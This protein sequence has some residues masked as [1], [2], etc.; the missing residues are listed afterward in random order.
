M[1]IIA[2]IQPNKYISDETIVNMFDNNPDGGGLMW[3]LHPNSRVKI[4][5]GFE[6]VNEL[7]KVFRSIPESAERAIHCRIATAGKIS[8]GCCHPFPLRNSTKTMKQAKDES[9][10][11]YMHNGIIDWCNPIG[12]H[13]DAEESDTMIFGRDILYR[14]KNDLDN[15]R[16]LDMIE[17][18]I[19]SSKLLI[20]R[21]NGE[22]IVLGRWVKDKNGILYS[23]DTYKYSYYNY[24]SI[25]WRGLS[26]NK[27]NSLFVDDTAQYDWLD[28]PYASAYC[29]GYCDQCLSTVCEYSNNYISNTTVRNTLLVF[30]VKKETCHQSQN[31]ILNDIES[32][33]YKVKRSTIHEADKVVEIDVVVEGGA[34]YDSKI[35][36]WG[37]FEP[38][39]KELL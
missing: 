5:K 1:C 21:N 38:A 10:I 24:S 25:N 27:C 39:E 7:I 30:I 32:K 13:M 28:N 33:G 8:V 16:I 26:D 18:S 2:Y 20:F 14:L 36:K 22:T 6:D 12:K 37:G 23:N 34:I 9:P 17:E 3:K 19:A 11:A 15:P 4:E 29:D 31:N 35:K